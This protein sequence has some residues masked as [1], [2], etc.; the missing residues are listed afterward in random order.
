MNAVTQ[1][2]AAKNCRCCREMKP[3]ED[4]S[5]MDSGLY[6]RHPRCR[7]CR[8]RRA[9]MVAEKRRTAGKVRKYTRR[10][11]AKVDLADGTR[12]TVGLYPPTAEEKSLAGAFAAY[13]RRAARP[14]DPGN[15]AARIY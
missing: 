14:G 6:G 3:L 4:F 5:P 9:Q 2:P 7:V 1:Y 10:N 8:N 13:M 15:V 12:R 11:L